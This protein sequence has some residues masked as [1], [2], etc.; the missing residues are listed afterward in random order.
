MLE[1]EI[2]TNGG[3]WNIIAVIIINN[4]CTTGSTNWRALC[5]NFT[6]FT[7]EIVRRCVLDIDYQ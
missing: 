5:V 4:Y 1:K 3:A 7:S 2:V 6:K